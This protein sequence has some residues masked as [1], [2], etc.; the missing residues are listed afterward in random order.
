MA[1][2]VSRLAA[3]TRER[4]RRRSPDRRRQR[5]ERNTL[6]ESFGALSCD[7]IISTVSKFTTR[8]GCGE[9]ERKSVVDCE[10]LLGAST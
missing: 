5:R 2:V 6:R 8:K 10:A 9:S 1:D 4:R 7:R 3:A